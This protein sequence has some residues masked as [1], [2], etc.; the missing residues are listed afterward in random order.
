MSPPT[1]GVKARTFRRPCTAGGAGALS[2]AVA[3]SESLPRPWGARRRPASSTGGACRRPRAEKQAERV[4][5][6]VPP[7]RPPGRSPP[8]RDSGRDSNGRTPRRPSAPAS[9]PPLTA[10]PDAPRTKTPPGAR[11]R[12]APL[13]V[14][15]P[16]EALPANG[17]PARTAATYWKA[18]SVPGGGPA[19]PPALPGQQPA[20]GRASAGIGGPQRAACRLVAAGGPTPRAL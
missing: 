4:Q 14:A 6:P 13:P 15:P 1:P 9:P 8:S 5:T 2:A 12:R 19:P 7:G 18:V 20:C 11:G 16:A 3:P 17:R 10:P